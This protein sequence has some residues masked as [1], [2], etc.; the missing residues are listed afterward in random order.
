[1]R[2]CC[3]NGVPLSCS[4]NATPPLRSAL[5]KDELWVVL[6]QVRSIVRGAA[7]I[8][9]QE[10]GS[11]EPREQWDAE[12][13]HREQPP[14]VTYPSH[15]W[16]SIAEGRNGQVRSDIAQALSAASRVFK[17]SRADD[18]TSLAKL[19]K[20]MNLV[21]NF[22]GISQEKL[23][24]KVAIYKGVKR[25]YAKKLE[26]AADKQGSISPPFLLPSTDVLKCV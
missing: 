18:I 10:K 2:V 17:T 9:P 20:L 15:L 21:L 5:G 22:N 14:S 6:Q 7:T 12:L 4:A 19:L 13:P 1:M 26:A 11:R 8:L 24:W 16:Q 23:R 3:V 25:R